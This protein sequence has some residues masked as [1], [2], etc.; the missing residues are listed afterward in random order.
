MCTFRRLHLLLDG[1]TAYS[2]VTKNCTY[3]KP[4]Q[5]LVALDKATKY[6][7]SEFVSPDKENAVSDQDGNCAPLLYVPFTLGSARDDNFSQKYLSTVV[8]NHVQ[9]NAD[10]QKTGTSSYFAVNNLLE[11]G[12]G[13]LSL[14]RIKASAPEEQ[15]EQEQLLSGDDGRIV[16]ESGRTEYF[17][18]SSKGSSTVQFLVIKFGCP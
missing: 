5:S 2:Q 12:K 16:V 3:E 8:T 10:T 11:G 4:Q 7:S 18:N 1:A 15:E 9:N 17:V 14:I 6:N 13:T